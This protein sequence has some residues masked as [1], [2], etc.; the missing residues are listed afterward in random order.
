MKLVGCKKN[1][2]P[3]VMISW[4]FKKS[5]TPSLKRNKT[6]IFHSNKVKPMESRVHLQ[7]KNHRTEPM[8]MNEPKLGLM[9]FC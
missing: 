9:K 8:A 5:S 2:D 1:N 4:P 6:T 3:S 7:K